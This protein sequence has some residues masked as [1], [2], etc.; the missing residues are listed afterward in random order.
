MS[1]QCLRHWACLRAQD[2]QQSCCP[3]AQ[4]AALVLGSLRTSTH[5]A[6]G[7][8]LLDQALLYWV[9]RRTEGLE[10]RGVSSLQLCPLLRGH[11]A[12]LGINF[13]TF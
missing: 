11:P 6:A 12:S 4:S 8:E 9:R 13:L 2:R 3:G 7:F 1:K 10:E 5:G